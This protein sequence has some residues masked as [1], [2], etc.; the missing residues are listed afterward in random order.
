M[1]R[2]PREYKLVEEESRRRLDALLD[3]ASVARLK[4]LYDAAQD[5]LVA[6]LRKLASGDSM[7]GLQLRSLLAQVRR[8][9]AQIAKVMVGALGEES[10]KA[11]RAGLSALLSDIAKLE[12][13]FTGAQVALPVAEAARFAGVVD[14]LRTSLMRAHAASMARYGSHLVEQME[15]ALGQ[16]LLTGE[17]GHQ[18]TDR[19][20]R[21]AQVEWW[22]AA[23]IVRTELS[24]ASAATAVAGARES[25]KEMPDLRLRWSE[26]VDDESYAPLDDRVAVD[27]IALHGQVARPGEPFVMPPSAPAPDARGETEVPAALVG[28]TWTHPPDRPNDRAVLAPWRPHWG[29]PGWTWRDGQRV[30]AREEAP[31]PKMQ[32][33]E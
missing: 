15:G 13:Q 3:G 27:S 20:A 7:T 29:V 6:K 5:E 8:G 9:Q 18:A 21:V 23:R 26:H 16:A 32:E 4:R 25:A 10:L 33:E 19:V 28:Q 11:Q 14:T 17:T 24:W 1:P 31:G 30:P 2:V 12:R 22:R